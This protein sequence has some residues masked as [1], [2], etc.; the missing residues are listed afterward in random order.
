[1]TLAEVI[2]NAADL[3]E[4]RGLWKGGEG[5]TAGAETCVTL[6]LD[7]AAGRDIRRFSESLNVMSDAVGGQ[8]IRWNDAPERTREEVVA[9]MRATAARVGGAR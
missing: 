2:N 9:T 3:I 5:Y 7:E 1:M 8:L 4:Q 6:A